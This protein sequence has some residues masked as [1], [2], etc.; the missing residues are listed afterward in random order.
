MLSLQEISDR[1]EIQQ[2][3]TVYANAID[4]RDFD[5]LDRVF[6]ADAY[7]DYRALGG[8]DGRFPA[9]KVW[10]AQV[11]PTFPRYTHLVGNI[12][13]EV[14]GDTARARTACIN[15]MEVTLP[16]GG[17]QVML[18]GLWYA[19]QLVRTCDGWRMSERVEE[20][21]FQHNVPEHIR[22]SAAS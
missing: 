15:P 9:I 20:P 3:I 22:T 18:L 21:G 11:L 2:L 6:T 12:E 10:L 19:D 7:I 1:M 17:T 8:I 13:V 16:G 14:S 5:A 4:R